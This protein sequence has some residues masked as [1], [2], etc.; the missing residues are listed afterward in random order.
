MC[1]KMEG[2]ISGI[3]RE[4]HHCRPDISGITEQGK[5]RR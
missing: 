3:L 1:D 2:G 4:T 5:T